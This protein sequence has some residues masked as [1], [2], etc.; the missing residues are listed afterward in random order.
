MRAIILF[1]I[2]LAGLV[3]FLADRHDCY[4]HG[5]DAWAAWTKCVIG[6]SRF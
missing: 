2:L 3:W 6:L 1:L 4:W 5:L